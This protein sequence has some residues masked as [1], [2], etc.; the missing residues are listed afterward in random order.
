MEEEKEEAG[1][2]RR[3]RTKD[4]S[5]GAAQARSGR[6]EEAGEGKSGPES[7]G[8]ALVFCYFWTLLETINVLRGE[9]VQGGVIS[10][11]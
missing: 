5:T 11:S 10:L 8:C 9:M 4:R 3:K 2:E 6:E 1:T 7:K